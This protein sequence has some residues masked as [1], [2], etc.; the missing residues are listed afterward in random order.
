MISTK[1]FDFSALENTGEQK[2]QVKS[3]NSVQTFFP[4]PG[5]DVNP[6][7]VKSEAVATNEISTVTQ[8]KVEK[9]AEVTALQ[10]L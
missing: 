9:D 6:Q 4:A 2:T 1:S 3:S 10:L 8:K 5:S 7:P